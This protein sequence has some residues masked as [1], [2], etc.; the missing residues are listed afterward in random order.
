MKISGCIWAEETESLKTPR[1]RSN[2]RKISHARGRQEAKTREHHVDRHKVIF[3][4]V[5]YKSCLELTTGIYVCNMVLCKWP[6]A[7]YRVRK[8]F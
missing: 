2:I 4:L 8:Q 7:V 3:Y 1:G 6:G 5:C